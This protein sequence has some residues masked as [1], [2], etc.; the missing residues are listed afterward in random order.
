MLFVSLPGAGVTC[1]A[2][3]PLSSLPPSLP[4]SP[5]A[6]LTAAMQSKAPKINDDFPS[7]WSRPAELAGLAAPL[8]FL[9]QV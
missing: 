2:S 9:S 8:K 3:P 7:A 5:P 1:P 4:S 6:S